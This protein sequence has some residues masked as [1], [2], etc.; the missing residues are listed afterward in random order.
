MST[1][2]SPDLLMYLGKQW[3]VI[4]VLGPL[5]LMWE[6]LVGFRQLF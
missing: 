5:A 4:Q 3:K 2:S 6:M 1:G